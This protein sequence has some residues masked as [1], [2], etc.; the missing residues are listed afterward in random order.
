MQ[1]FNRWAVVLLGFLALLLLGGLVLWVLPDAPVPKEELVEEV[2]E[3]K[4]TQES[5]GSSLEGRSID[6]HT[7]G[8][9]EIKLLFV[10]GIHGG[11]EWNSA[12]LS[13][14]LITYIKKNPDLIPENITVAIIPSLNPD[15]IFKVVGKEGMFSLTDVPA[16]DKSSARFN[17]RGVDLNRNFDCKWQ[18]DAT[19]RGNKVS[20]GTSAFSE[21][22]AMALKRYVETYEPDAVV[23]YHSQSNAVYASE[24][25]NGIL[26][27]TRTL[28]NTYAAAAGYPPVDVF[29]AY[30]VTGDSE[31]WLASIGIPAVSVELSTHESIEWEK[32]LKGVQALFN[33]YGN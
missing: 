6:V 15:A 28:M 4:P 21:P 1:P 23:V 22:E 32:N 11:Y 27:G 19:W 8:N 9:G 18:K 12:L 14:E 5:I 20:A 3:G 2:E 25:E 16:G 10:G 29:D 24:C 17:A 30:P 13:Y 7:F 31:G 33:T 26:P